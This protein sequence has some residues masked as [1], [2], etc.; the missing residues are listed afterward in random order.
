MTDKRRQPNNLEMEQAVLGASLLDSEALPKIVE[1]LKDESAFY[2]VKHRAIFGA[3]L[4]LFSEGAAIDLLTVSA[5]IKKAGYDDPK[6]IEYLADLMDMTPTS[7]NV[8]AHAAIV[9][10]AYTLRKMI[11]A[12]Q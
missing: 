6:D 8:G 10:D 3:M 2:Q 5:R 11:V 1:I 12:G 9:R 4:A 7:A